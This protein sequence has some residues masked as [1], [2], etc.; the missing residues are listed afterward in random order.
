MRMCP[1]PGRKLTQIRRLALGRGNTR[2]DL[3]SASWANY[4]ATKKLSRA[5]T[6]TGFEATTSPLAY[7]TSWTP[8]ARAFV[9]KICKTKTIRGGCGSAPKLYRH[10]QN[11]VAADSAGTPMIPA[12]LVALRMT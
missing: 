8:P 4:G 3:F 6:V 9:A 7:S 12:A 11:I 10:S 2:D 5:N 1:D